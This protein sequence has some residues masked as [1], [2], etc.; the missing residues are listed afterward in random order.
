M[1]EMVTGANTEG[2]L[3]QHSGFIIR[4][5]FKGTLLD[6]DGKIKQ[7]VHASNLVVTIGL[8]HIIDQLHSSPAQAKMS[9]YAIG[10]GTIAPAAV[11]T[12]LQTQVY[13]K[14]LD[15]QSKSGVQ[16]TYIGAFSPGEGTGNI[17][18]GGIFNASSGGTMLARVVFTAVNK[19]ASDTFII[20]HTITAS[21]V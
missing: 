6:K 4:T 9:H 21:A 20:N 14:T 16:I 13:R 8:Q 11:D 7:V 3:R 19:T 10:T 2:I 1:A 17:T 18:E 5:N 12:S 15:S